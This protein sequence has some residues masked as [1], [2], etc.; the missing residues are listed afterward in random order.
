MVDTRRRLL[1]GACVAATGAAAGAWLWRRAATDAPP[2]H[3]HDLASTA[4]PA[5]AAG[6]PAA[7]TPFEQP[8]RLPGVDGLMADV[9]LAGAM[10]LRASTAAFPIFAGAATTLWHYAGEVAGR[11]V[12]NPVL[13]IARGQTLDIALDNALAEAT[14][15][16]WHGLHVDE[17]NDGSGLHPVAPGQQ[18]RYRLRVDN[19]AG[20]YW[21]HAHPHQRTGAQL[22]YGMA[23]LLLVEDAEELALR[24]RLGLRW[25]ERDLPLLIADKQVD[26]NNAVVYRDGADDWIGNRM[27]VNWTPEPTHEV[28]AGLYRLRLANVCNARVLRPA[29]LHGDRPLTF[30]LIGTDGGLLAEPWPVED[31]F[32]APG[33]RADVLVDFAQVPAGERVLL[34]SLD[35]VPME[36]ED[37]SGAFMPDPMGE[38]PG[39]APMGAPV[40][41]MQFCVAACGAAAS[42]GT[43]ATAPAR[44]ASLPATLSALPPPPDTRGWPVRPLRLHM[45]SEGTWFI[46]GRNF[47]RDGHEPA[48][49]VRRGAREVWEIRNAMTSMPH[50]IHVHGV[51]FR[52][53]SR[54]ISPQDVRSRQVAGPG[55]GPQDLGFSDTV[56][57]WPGEVVR[58]AIDFSQPFEGEQRY[59]VHCH[60]L[61]H[62]DM[63]MMLT[64][65]VTA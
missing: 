60:N 45:D 53:V 9:R 27:L 6:T 20:L 10:T 2:S 36:N 15:A 24:E 40:D 13:R 64:F 35:Y 28:V 22:Q 56:L 14:T 34:R 33:Q 23:G 46:N 18:R 50:P 17:A 42:T 11:G 65:A 21:Y 41:L 1:L 54:S 61:E 3:G 30:H 29:F 8:L 25:C 31:L 4:A 51:Q 47:H 16:H 39:A 43:V 57:V 62:E 32:L 7:Y 26:A 52:V 55:L 49:A 12:A 44:A 63:G 5:G 19:R 37:E 38:H 59:M 58:I 48:F